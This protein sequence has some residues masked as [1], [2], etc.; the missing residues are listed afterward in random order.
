M[1]SKRGN[2]SHQRPPLRFQNVLFFL[3]QYVFPVRKQRGIGRGRRGATA[4][5]G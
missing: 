2:L 1:E 4:R 5:D 3:I